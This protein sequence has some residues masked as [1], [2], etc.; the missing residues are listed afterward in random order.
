V[1]IILKKNNY[2]Q[3]LERSMKMLSIDKRVLFIGQ[4]V[5][6]SGNAIFN[7]LEGIDKKKKI[8]LP[9]FEE[10]QMGLSLGLA[11]QGFVP[12]TIYP[13]IDFLL[14]ATNQ[15]VNHLD[16]IRMMSKGQFNPKVIIR[17]SVASKWPLDGGPQHT[18][19]HT[20]AMKKLLTTVKVHKFQKPSEIFR[21]YKK[22]I[23][24]SD[25]DSHL[26]IEDASYYNSKN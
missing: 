17:T 3:E 16:K 14:S 23:S 7:T 25:K 1:D 21:T 26:V 2:R 11:L 9:V 24:K 12:V 4:S 20:E 15:L 18:Q 10:T 22:I 19:D 13:R 8:E 5:K 6:Y